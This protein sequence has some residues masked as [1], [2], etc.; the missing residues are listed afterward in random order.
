[1]LVDP[2]GISFAL[3]GGGR[4]SPGQPLLPGITVETAYHPLHPALPRLHL[5]TLDSNRLSMNEA[6]PN[7]KGNAIDLGGLPPETWVADLQ[8]A[9]EVIREGLPA[10]WQEAGRSLERLLPVGVE[11]E[12]HLSA[13][14]QEAPNMAYLTLHPDRLTMAEA[15]I[16]ETQHGRLNTLM[17]LDAVLVNGQSAWTTSPVRPDM[18]PLSGVLLAV[19]AFTPVA[20]L[21]ASLA[22]SGHPLAQ[23]PHF[24][25]RRQEVLEGN[26][27]GLETLEAMAEP[28][29]AGRRLLADLRLLHDATV[30]H[31]E[32]PQR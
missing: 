17:W 19:H 28:T 13:S 5:A 10:W 16:H 26:A 14:Y 24:A 18:R 7:K 4:W 29:A 32:H 8:A 11:P 31:V 27:R 1:M 9:L 2:A 12:L 30:F 21:H 6:H 3:D 20:A 22:A 23:A 15:I 25:R